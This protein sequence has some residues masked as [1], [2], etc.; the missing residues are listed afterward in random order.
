MGVLSNQ[1][2]L[3]QC[4]ENL[5]MINHLEF[6][7]EL[8]YQLALARFGGNTK[9]YLGNVGS[10]GGVNIQTA[11]AQALQCED[12]LLQHD[13]HDGNAG[14]NDICHRGML[15]EVNDRNNK[16][17]HQATAC[18]IGAVTMLEEYFSIRIEFRKS[19]KESISSCRTNNDDVTG[20]AILTCLPVLLDGHRPQQ[21]AL[22]IF[23]LRLA[24]QVDWTKEKRCFHGISKEIGN[25]YAML[26]SQPEDLNSYVQHNLFPAFSY[27][28]LPSKDQ[29]R[30]GYYTNMSKLSTLYKVF[31]RC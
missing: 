11:I 19:N 28:L 1:R 31:E 13:E 15:L 24:T 5:V 10:N 9:A 21:H 18:L 30:N 17:A 16:L 8:F 14:I 7:K 4:G 2:S 12:D 3:I 27:L 25:F 6:G 29:V 26:P 23:L 20:D 22:P